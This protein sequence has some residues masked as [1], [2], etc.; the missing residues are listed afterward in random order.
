MLVCVYP[1]SESLC[2][3]RFT[4][5]ALLLHTFSVLTL[6][7]VEDMCRHTVV[8]RRVFAAVKGIV[9]GGEVAP[10]AVGLLTS[11]TSPG[12]TPSH[13]RQAEKLQRGFLRSILLLLRRKNGMQLV[14][15]GG[16]IHTDLPRATGHIEPVKPFLPKL[17]SAP[18]SPLSLND[19]TLGTALGQR[20]SSA[21]LRP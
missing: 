19:P 3:E 2:V 11:T 6:F 16:G 9:G 15:I 20:T 10:S 21:S 17:P 7:E 5:G 12:A 1:R 18:S 14:Q 8:R 4:R 13:C